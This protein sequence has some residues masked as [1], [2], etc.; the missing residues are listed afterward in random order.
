MPFSVGLYLTEELPG[1][2]SRIRRCPTEKGTPKVWSRIKGHHV[3]VKSIK[4]KL[5][6][7]LKSR[8]HWI[9]RA[10]DLGLKWA[11]ARN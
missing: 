8:S 7:E 11:V 4:L 6:L 10:N 3:H 2:A 1:A 5:K 9:L